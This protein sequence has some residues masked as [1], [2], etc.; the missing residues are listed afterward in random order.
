M[1]IKWSGNNSESFQVTSLLEWEFRWS[2]ASLGINPRCQL[3][4]KKLLSQLPT[5]Q[6][7][8]SACFPFHPLISLSV[9]DHCQQPAA[10]LET[11]GGALY[12]KWRSAFLLCFVIKP[13]VQGIIL[14]I[15]SYVH[16]TFSPF[17]ILLVAVANTYA[18]KGLDRI[19]EKLPILNQ[20]TN[21]VS[22]GRSAKACYL[23]RLLFN[24][25]CA[26]LKQEI[27]SPHGCIFERPLFSWIIVRLRLKQRWTSH[28]WTTV[29]LVWSLL[30][31]D[32]CL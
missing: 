7:T 16:L 1:G 13:K 27:F 31:C 12:N 5:W 18:C 30:I 32:F 14:Y 28:L 6:V 24:T 22:S 10:E 8:A 23:L 11:L 19:E 26:Y 20:P 21:Q 3:M 29:L 4:R 2:L 25:G 15:H 9:E 17:V